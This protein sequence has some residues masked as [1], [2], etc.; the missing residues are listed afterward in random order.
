MDTTLEEA[1]WR[2]YVIRCGDD[3]FYTGITTNVERRLRQHQQGTGAK[4]T[5]GRHPLQLWWVSSPMNHQQALVQEW[6]IKQWSH[7]EKEALQN[8]SR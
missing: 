4:Y 2:V 7:A 8:S 6:Q 5:R 3:T 1:R